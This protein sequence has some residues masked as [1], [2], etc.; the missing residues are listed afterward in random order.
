MPYSFEE[1]GADRSI[2]TR[3]LVEGIATGAA[4]EDGDGIITVDELHRYAGR[5]VKETSPVMSPTLITLKDEG[6]RIRIARSPQDDPKLKYR[7]EAERRATA[8]EFTIPAKRLLMALRTELGLLEAEAEAIEA[9]VLKPHREYQR[10]QQEYQEILRQC[11]ER[12]P[13]LSS[14]TIDDLRDYRAHLRL[15]PED[16]A[17]IERVALDND[18][19]GYAESLERQ[20]KQ[21]QQ[22]QEETRRRQRYEQEFSRALAAG[23]PLD[24]FVREG[25]K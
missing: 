10:K 17:A 8:A 20:S 23:Y 1:K 19:E 13:S 21:E 11:L 7:K 18:L 24:T 4:D 9:E 5:K 22:Q 25:L 2:Y 14:R 3:Y 15:K 16:V 6:F 12:E